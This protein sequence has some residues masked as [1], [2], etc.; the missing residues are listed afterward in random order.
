M[1]GDLRRVEV[2]QMYDAGPRLAHAGQDASFGRSY[3]V[4]GETLPEFRM[5][6]GWWLLPAVIG[7]SVGWFMVISAVFF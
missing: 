5:P 4:R 2:A 3:A 7:G 1:W 6:P